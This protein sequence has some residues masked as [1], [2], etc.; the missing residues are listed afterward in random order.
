M[1]HLST[2][3]ATVA[4][5]LAQY[6]AGQVITAQF[7]AYIA[8]SDAAEAGIDTCPFD[9]HA[10]PDLATQWER[11]RTDTLDF[12]TRRKRPRGGIDR[13]SARARRPA[14]THA[15]LTHPRDE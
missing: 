13:L 7:G 5:A 11:G 14:T 15:A 10:L 4:R 1:T 8:G 3:A 9:P 6:Q 2:H 12:R